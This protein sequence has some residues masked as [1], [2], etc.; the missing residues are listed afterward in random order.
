MQH[1]LTEQQK[2]II[3]LAARLVQEDIVPIAE[4]KQIVAFYDGKEWVDL[5]RE[6]RERV[7]QLGEMN[8][9]D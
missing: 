4:M 1:N 6:L 8:S 7:V 5:R 9:D 2:L 3:T